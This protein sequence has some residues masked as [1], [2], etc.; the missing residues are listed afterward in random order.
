MMNGVFKKRNE[1]NTVEFIRS[2]SLYARNSFASKHATMEWKATPGSLLFS[3]RCFC[4][5]LV[6]EERLILE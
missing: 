2:P 1:K 6:S 5:V 3:I 4:Q